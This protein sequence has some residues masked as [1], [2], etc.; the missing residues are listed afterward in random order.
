MGHW[1]MFSC[2][3][4]WAWGLVAGTL[5]HR[6]GLLITLTLISATYE[7]PQLRQWNNK[8]M[9]Y[10]SCGR[11]RRPKQTAVADTPSQSRGGAHTPQWRRQVNDHC[12]KWAA[13][14]VQ[15]QRQAAETFRQDVPL[16][17][18]QLPKMKQ[19]HDKQLR[20]ARGP[21]AAERSRV[22]Y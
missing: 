16:L 3:S 21:A 20:A 6:I 15:Q 18:P 11:I 19:W 1:S 8:F 2:A 9:N 5:V 22:A 4:T 17:A 12:Q 7:K 14:Q 13:L 10:R